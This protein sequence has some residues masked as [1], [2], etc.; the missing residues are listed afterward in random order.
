M[1]AA[2]RD[3]RPQV[4]TGRHEQRELHDPRGSHK[5]W[6]AVLGMVQ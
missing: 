2:Q 5:G 3:W 4:I 6:F 1:L